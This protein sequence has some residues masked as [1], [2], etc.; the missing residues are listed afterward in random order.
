MTTVLALATCLPA[1][2]DT[3][4][5][6]DKALKIVQYG[7]WA[8]TANNVEASERWR[9]AMAAISGTRRMLRAGK[10]LPSLRAAAKAA[11]V[12]RSAADGLRA[13]MWA[14]ESAASACDAGYYLADNA[15][16]VSSWG[17]VSS[18][19][20]YS[21]SLDHVA[22]LAW[23]ASIVLRA[24]GALLSLRSAPSLSALLDLLLLALDAVLSA[25][26]AA[27]AAS[28]PFL[29]AAATSGSLMTAGDIVAQSL[30]RDQA[31]REG[32][33]VPAHDVGR[34]FVMASWGLTVLP[35]VWAPWY[36]LLDRV[37]SATGLK[38]ALAKALLTAV[39][40]APLSNGAFFAYST[41]VEYWM[42]CHLPKLLAPLPISLSRPLAP[43]DTRPLALVAAV[44][45]ERAASLPPPVIELAATVAEADAQQDALAAD[46][47]P[48]PAVA[49]DKRLARFIPP[50]L[51]HRILTKLTDEMPGTV[52]G[53]FTIWVPT[54][55]I[56]WWLIPPTL[57][58]PATSTISVLW[59]SYLSLA[60]HRE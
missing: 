27:A 32:M 38:G 14:L 28:R 15:S 37:I 59:N 25:R 20:P 17:V 31:R 45:S 19:A 35:A 10:A 11:G 53:S 5:G 16:V 30:E 22:N 52:V 3:T 43:P 8:A 36:P 57:R 9:P 60:Q 21:A 7:V 26:Y 42:E 49:A 1:T 24:P 54:N 6:Y 34:T 13:L 18:P 23:A 50:E 40:M 41:S 44:V 47:S 46:A 29:T 51:T 12:A 56:A 55:T 2:L 58:F 33:P 39:T 4:Y 48:V